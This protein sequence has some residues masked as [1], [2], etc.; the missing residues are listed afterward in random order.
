[1]P[2][3]RLERVDLREVWP[4]EATDFTR[5]LAEPDNLVHL[6]DAIGFDLDV[7]TAEASVGKFSVDILAQE[8]GTGRKVIIENQLEITDHDHLGK[9]LTYAAG[10]DASMVIWVVKK[11]REEHRQAI[12]WLND[13]TIEDIGFFLLRIEAWRIGDSDPAPKFEIVAKPNNWTKVVREADSSN[14]ARTEL[15]LQQLEFWEELKEYAASSNFHDLRFQ[16]SYDQHWT[17]LSI[18]VS[19]AHIAFTINSKEKQLATEL[20]IADHKDWYQALLAE[21]EQIDIEL[22]KFGTVDWMLLPDRKASR[23][24]VVLNADFREPGGREK[25]FDWLLA[26]GSTF[27]QV[28][29]F[30]LRAIARKSK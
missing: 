29:S 18:G 28:F 16:K 14:R 7:I 8:E 22:Q 15:K 1:M 5:W 12:D 2:L 23:I 19:G 9:L 30:R 6:S 17:N 3:S 13:N 20:Y 27:K 21:R 4:H 25:I 26:S 24:K 11:E 10:H